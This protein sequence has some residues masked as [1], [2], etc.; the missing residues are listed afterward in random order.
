MNSRIKQY[1]LIA[2]IAAAGYFVLNNHFIFNGME[3]YLLK[4]D[5][6][7]LHSTFYSIKSKSPKHIMKNDYLRDAGIGDLLVELGIID[8]VQRTKLE[9]EFAYD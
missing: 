1:I 7:H 3:V 5:S 2:V 4:K 8:E 6:L 9:N